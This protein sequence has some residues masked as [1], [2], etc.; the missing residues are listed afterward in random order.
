MTRK[1]LEKIIIEMIRNADITSK[2]DECRKQG[3]LQCDPYFLDV[4]DQILIT[5][6]C[7]KCYRDSVDDI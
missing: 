6:L 3:L 2:C 7:P 5:S 1:E 4:K